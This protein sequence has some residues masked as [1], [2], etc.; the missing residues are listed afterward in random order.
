[1]RRTKAEAE[2]TREAVLAGAIDVFL[3]RGVTRAT[4]EQ[5]ASAAGV[6]RGA[7]YWH[8]KDKQEI[9]IALERRA[10]LPS[11][12]LGARLEA[13]LAAE[14]ELD[15][16]AEL[17]DAIEEGL[18]AFEKDPER[19]RILTIL[20]LRCDYSEELLPALARQREADLALQ[21]L[22]ETVI[23]IA[24]RRDGLAPGWS[25]ETAARALLLLVNGSVLDWLR[26][27]GKSVLTPGTMKLVA[28][29]LDTVSVRAGSPE[30]STA[31]LKANSR[32][33]F[34]HPQR[35]R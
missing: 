5:I 10:N 35:S 12:E 26:A 32:S 14:P 6:T 4:L 15:P 19:S 16:L 27:P 18:R 13:R 8:F 22:F 3:E 29:F 20:W 31:R 1:M 11:D 33:S 9:F 7:I 2:R 34:R 28:A 24:A 17:K 21:R 23:G 25:V 30:R